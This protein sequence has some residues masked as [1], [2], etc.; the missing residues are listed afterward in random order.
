MPRVRVSD[1]TQG[2]RL[3]IDRRRRNMTQRQAAKRHGMTLYRYRRCEMDESEAMPPIPAIGRLKLYEELR[4]L[5]VR[6][7]ATVHNVA[8]DMGISRWWVTQM[9]AGK[10]PCD[11][12]AEYWGVCV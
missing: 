12:L 3:V 1:L 6:E 2:E 5:R 11:R 4:V 8:E 9:E 7:G 10:A